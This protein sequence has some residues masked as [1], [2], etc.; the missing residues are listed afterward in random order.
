MTVVLVN[1]GP[2]HRH[3]AQPDR[4][5]LLH[6][7][8]ND[9]AAERGVLEALYPHVAEGAAIILDD[10]GWDHYKAQREGA[11]AF[12]AAQGNEVLELP[13]GQGLVIK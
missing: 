9:A 11:D 3:R 13:T 7:D 2:A 1:A 5:A 8:L 10:Y 6:V 4:I 12:F